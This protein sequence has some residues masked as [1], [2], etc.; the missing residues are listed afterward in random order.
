VVAAIILL[1]TARASYRNEKGRVAWLR[2]TPDEQTARSLLDRILASRERSPNG[3]RLD[4]HSGERPFATVHPTLESTTFDHVRLRAVDL[5]L[6]GCKL[7]ER[8]SAVDAIRQM[9]V[10]AG[11]HGGRVR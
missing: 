2:D 10:D 3:E 11:I 7:L 5:G 8:G 4:G 6:N 9:K 1:D